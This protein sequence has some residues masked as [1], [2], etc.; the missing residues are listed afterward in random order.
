MQTWSRLTN[1]GARRLT[2]EV[3]TS[4]TLGGIGDRDDCDDPIA[5]L[6]LWSAD[7]DWLAEGRWQRRAVREQGHH[8]AG[9]GSDSGVCGA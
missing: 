1:R 7:N 4:F 3:V 6:D 9:A 2:L 5:S 8:R